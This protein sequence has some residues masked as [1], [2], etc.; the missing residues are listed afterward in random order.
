MSQV[1]SAKESKEEVEPDGPIK[2]IDNLTSEFHT[3]KDD[4]SRMKAIYD[5]TREQDDYDVDE[6]DKYANNLTAI[7]GRMNEL[8]KEARLMI[9]QAYP[10]AN[11]DQYDL[12]KKQLDDMRKSNGDEKT[13]KKLERIMRHYEVGLNLVRV[14]S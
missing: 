3:L 2:F 8:L 1:L 14:P 13:I 6:V 5:E 7:K 9:G 4:F 10:D 11:K 12:I